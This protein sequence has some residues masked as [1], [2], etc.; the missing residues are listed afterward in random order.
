MLINPQVKESFDKLRDAETT[1]QSY[2]TNVLKEV[3]KAVELSKGQ[4][5]EVEDIIY[6]RNEFI[7]KP[8]S[9]TD[10]QNGITLNNGQVIKLNPNQI[11]AYKRI[12]IAQ[13][14]ILNIRMTTKLYPYFERLKTQTV[15]TKEYN[16]TVSKIKEISAYFQ[17]SKRFWL[18]FYSKKWANCPI[19]RRPCF[20][21]W[22]Y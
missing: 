12:R 11:E 2:K 13:D 18:Y 7:Q 6:E 15:G 20:S 16:D 14:N 5:K 3:H 4:E 1:V 22:R 10:L 8:I 9:D 19:C 21:N 17:K